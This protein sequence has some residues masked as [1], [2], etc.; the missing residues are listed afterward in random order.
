MNVPSIRLFRATL[1]TEKCRLRKNRTSGTFTTQSQGRVQKV[2]NDFDNEVNMMLTK[3]KMTEQQTLLL[4]SLTRMME[5]YKEPYWQELD[6]KGEYPTKLVDELGKSGFMGIPISEEYGGA[7]LGIKEASMI[8]EEI[9][10]SGGNA[11]PFHGQYY[12]SWIMSKFAKESIKREYMPKLARGEIRMQS[13]ALTEPEAGSETA[14]IK[15]FAKKEGDK[16]VINGHK[17]FASRVKYS[18]LM[19]LVTRTTPYEEVTKKTDGL[20]IFLVDLRKAKGLEVNE[21]KTIFNSQTY[22]LFIEN[23]E[24]P[25]EN[26]IG[27]L[28]NGFRHILDALNPERI[29][30]ASESIGD[31]RWFIEKSV[32][33]ANSRRVFDRP[34]GQ[35][36]GIQ[37]P[38][39]NVYAKL[40]GANAVR[41]ESVELYD[42]GSHDMKRIG[43]L[44]NIA[45]YLA[46]ECAWEAANVT[47][48]TYAGY[49]VAV[50]TGI[51]RKFRESRLYKIAPISSN[52]ILTYIG[53]NVL[54]MPKSY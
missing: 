39:A 13:M 40:V 6:K 28:G 16:Y 3:P 5:K 37:F 45:K 25:E 47:M 9:N 7:G 10:A 26:L 17:I 22:E 15:T 20:S 30:L 53:H 35:N 1:F 11:Q 46:S 34:I 38:I 50:D 18:D 54:G 41:W 44:A 12:L 29:L 43:E 19:V 49:G 4:Q 33:Y 24:V 31:A 27:E 14:K 23:L 2:Y 21:I 32:E 36:Q 42:S 51:Q 48:D 8:L 52:L